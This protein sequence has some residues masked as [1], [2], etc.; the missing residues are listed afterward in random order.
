MP[1]VEAA[2]AA[3]LVAQALHNA[4]AITATAAFVASLL[5]GPGYGSPEAEAEATLKSKRD[6]AECNEEYM[7]GLLQRRMRPHKIQRLLN[8]DKLADATSHNAGNT[9]DLTDTEVAAAD[10]MDEEGPASGPA[11]KAEE[12]VPG[13]PASVIGASAADT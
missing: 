6:V 11:H 9:I 13:A 12:S 5:A 1:A 10:A 7:H 4:R 3:E 8:M 2:A